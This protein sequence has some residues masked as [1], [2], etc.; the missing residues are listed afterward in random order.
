[1]ASASPAGGG[2]LNLVAHTNG[3]GR[4]LDRPRRRG[5]AG[6]GGGWHERGARL[7]LRAREMVELGDLLLHDGASV[8]EY[9][10]VVLPPTVFISKFD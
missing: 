8:L 4:V 3:A 7:A 2:S 5:R 9:S 1:M 10:N 6:G